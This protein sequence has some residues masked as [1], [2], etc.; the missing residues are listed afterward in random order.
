MP[1][2]YRTNSF[3]EPKLLES[4]GIFDKSLGGGHVIGRRLEIKFIKKC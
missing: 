3:K 4:F 2:P 1:K